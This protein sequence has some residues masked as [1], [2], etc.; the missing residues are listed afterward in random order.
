MGYE[1]YGTITEQLNPYR[2]KWEAIAQALGFKVYEIDSI[3]VDPIIM[4]RGPQACLNSVISQWLNW[5][6]GDP[7]GSTDSATLEALKKA[8]RKLGLTGLA[9]SLTL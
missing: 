8:V 4:L 7:R 1:H 3:K 9:K 5:A 2:A 6:N